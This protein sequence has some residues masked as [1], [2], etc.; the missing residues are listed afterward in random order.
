MRFVVRHEA[1]HRPVIGI[2]EVGALA[3]VGRDRDGGDRG[4][5]P[6]VVERVE[7]RIEAPH[8]HRAGDVQLLADRPREVDVEARRI[9]VRTRI[10]ERRIIDLGHEADQGDAAHVGPLGTPA[11]VPEPGH[12]R[13]RRR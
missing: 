1:R 5:A 12:A 3:R 9:A 6:V 8:L 11:R 7:Q 10:V 4:V 2:A 13:G